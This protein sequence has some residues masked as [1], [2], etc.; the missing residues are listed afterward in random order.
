MRARARPLE[1][2][3]GCRFPLWVALASR[4]AGPLQLLAVSGVCTETHWVNWYGCLI[5]L[6]DS[7]APAQA[8]APG[9]LQSASPNGLSVCPHHSLGDP[10][11][12]AIRIACRKWCGG[13]A[14]RGVVIYTPESLNYLLRTRLFLTQTVSTSFV[15][16]AVPLSFTTLTTVLRTEGD[17]GDQ[18][19]GYTE[20]FRED[21]FLSLPP[22]R[23]LSQLIC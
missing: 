15:S 12:T 11:G 22:L 9:H 14:G 10:T 1:R 23:L 19:E 8:G 21:S 5:H 7:L 18:P 6:H 16:A 2:A 3:E 17:T 20:G 4:G 13:P